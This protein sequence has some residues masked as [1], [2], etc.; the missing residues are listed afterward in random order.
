MKPG[1][2]RRTT[3]DQAEATEIADEAPIDVSNLEGSNFFEAG[4]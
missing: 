3:I 4:G 1:I 2:P